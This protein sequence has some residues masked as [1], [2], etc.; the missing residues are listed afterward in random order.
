VDLIAMKKPWMRGTKVWLIQC[1]LRGSLPKEEKKKLVK[2]AGSLHLTPVLAKKEKHRIV[3][4]T[5]D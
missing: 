1:K 4:D 2:L 3:F 5:L